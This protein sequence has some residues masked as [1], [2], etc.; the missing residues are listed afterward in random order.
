MLVVRPFLLGTKALKN[1]FQCGSQWRIDTWI[2]TRNGGS[3]Q[4]FLWS[5]ESP[6]CKVTKGTWLMNNMDGYYPNI[7][8]GVAKVT[9]GLNYFPPPYLQLVDPPTSALFSLPCFAQTCA[10]QG[11]TCCLLDHKGCLLLIRTQ[12]TRCVAWNLWEE[13]LCVI[14]WLWLLIAVQLV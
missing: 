13:R 10:L 11:C 8:E 6:N 7:S 2:P 12:E 3:K 5:F 9:D 4:I 1:F 14:W